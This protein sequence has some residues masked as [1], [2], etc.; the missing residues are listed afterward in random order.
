METPRKMVVSQNLLLLLA[1]F[2]LVFAHGGIVGCLVDILAASS[3]E[4]PKGVKGEVKR[5]PKS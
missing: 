1:C 2:F 5:G 4:R 3:V